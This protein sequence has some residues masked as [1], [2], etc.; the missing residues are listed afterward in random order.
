MVLLPKGSGGYRGIGLLEII[1]KLMSLIVDSRLKESIVFH[2]TLHG[3]CRTRG[4]GTGVME[5]K[6]SQQLAVLRQEPF[7][8]I[9]LDLKKAYDALDRK[10]T[11]AILEG[12][13]VGPNVI[14]LLRNFWEQQQVVAKQ[15]GFFGEAFPATRG[16]TQG[17]IVSPTLFNIVVDAVVRYWLF[18]M[19]LDEDST[20][21]LRHNVQARQVLFYADDGLVGSTSA[22]WLQQA[23]DELIAIFDRVGLRTN[24]TKTKVMVCVPGS[25]RAAASQEAYKRR[26]GEPGDSYRARKRRRV[27]CPECTKDLAAGSLVHHLRNRHGLDPQPVNPLP[28]AADPPLVPMSFPRHLEGEDVPCPLPSCPGK[29]TTRSTMR[30]HFTHRHRDSV[31]HIVEDGPPPQPCDLCGMHV[32]AYAIRRGHR[33][34]GVCNAGAARRRQGLALRRSQEALNRRFTAYGIELEQV[35]NFQSSRE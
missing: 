4:T 26:M 3:F 29:A 1:W 17:D 25:I 6:L 28:T 10:R 14:Q 23:F 31:L 35:S 20:T 13:G 5:A 34:S 30:R 7:Y 22:D 11:L 12:Y 24:P 2:D 27:S 33:F 9:F 32:T 19:G 21:G 8:A 18:T 16:V 15:S